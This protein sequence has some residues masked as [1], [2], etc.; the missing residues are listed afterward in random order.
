VS[1]DKVPGDVVVKDYSGMHA[2][3]ECSYTLECS[4][5]QICDTQLS[6][7]ALVSEKQVEKLEMVCD[8]LTQMTP[9]FCHVYSEEKLNNSLF[10]LRKEYFKNI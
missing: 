5:V 7:D 1:S 2:G 6:S 9:G 4:R 10:C 8:H 3:K